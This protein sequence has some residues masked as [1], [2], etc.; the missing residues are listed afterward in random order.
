LEVAWDW[1][2]RAA[3]LAG[4]KQIARMAEADDD[5]VLLRERLKEL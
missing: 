2:K 3:G 5:L 1:L 4:K